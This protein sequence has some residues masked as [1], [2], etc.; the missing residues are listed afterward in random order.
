MSRDRL[1]VG[2]LSASLSE[3]LQLDPD[4]TLEKAITQV[5]QAEAIATAATDLR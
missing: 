5:R 2:L 1:V 4:L 3:E